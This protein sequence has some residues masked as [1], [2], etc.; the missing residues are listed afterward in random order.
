M[1]ED[2]EYD[3]DK[4]EKRFHDHAL[5]VAFAP[6][7]N[8]EVVVSVILENAGGGNTYAAPVARAMLEQY[9]AK[10]IQVAQR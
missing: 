1:K 9:F 3:P 2:E 5:F 7:D 4:I 10:N 6:F 8:P